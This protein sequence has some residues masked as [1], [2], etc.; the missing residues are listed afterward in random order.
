MP[1]GKSRGISI[2]KVR[3]SGV[4]CRDLEVSGVSRRESFGDEREQLDMLD[5]VV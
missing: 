3:N 2:G 5:T 1:L 4:V